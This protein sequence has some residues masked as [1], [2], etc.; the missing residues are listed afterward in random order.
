MK[1]L[2]QGV[3]GE[4]VQQFWTSKQITESL[5]W[6][7]TYEEIYPSNKYVQIQIETNCFNAYPNF[8]R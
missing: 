8:K 7:S 2:G 4:Y 1:Q 6:L 3:L 5:L